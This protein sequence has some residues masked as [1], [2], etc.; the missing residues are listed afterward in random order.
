MKKWS[1]KKKIIIINTFFFAI[2]LGINLYILKTASSQILSDQTS[3]EIIDATLEI[4]NEIK[5]EDD[6]VYLEESE[7]DEVFRYYH[8]GVVF[9]VYESSSVAFGPVPTNFNPNIPIEINTIQ[10]QETSGITWLV[11][12]VDLENGYILRGIYDINPMADSV[13]NVIIFATIF[14]P[15]IILLSALGGYLIIKRSFK[16]IKDIYSTASIIK[17][18]EDYS[19]RIPTHFAKDEVYELADMVNQM[20]DQVEQ[21]INREK[22]FSSNVSHELRTPLTVMKAHAEYLLIKEKD[23]SVKSDIVTIMSQIS[24]MEN[25]VNQLLELTRTRHLSRSELDSIELYELVKLTS[26][27]FT[28]KL[29]DNHIS[30]EIIPP[31]FD[32]SVVCNQTMMI[33]AFSNLINNA[34]KYNRPNGSI[35]IM[36]NKTANTIITTIADTGLGIE[37]EKIAKIFDPFYRA[38]ESRTQDDASLGLGLALVKEIIQIHDGVIQV[39]SV[40]NIGTSFFISLPINNQE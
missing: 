7:D 13:R 8:D 9:L 27:S 2:L 14:S 30:L 29:E 22:Q 35:K 21:S 31:N 12:D 20:L 40:E 16:P 25:I 10:T 39:Q 15:I 4:A 5:I 17:N 36:F 3:R 23:K 32:T 26:E 18:E 34:I 38:S 24:L 28:Q 11:Y 33:R 19:K 37:K 6:Q 1:I